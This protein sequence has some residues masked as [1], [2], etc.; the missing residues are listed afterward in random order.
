MV[1]TKEQIHK[2]DARLLSTVGCMLGD[3]TTYALEGSIFSA[4]TSIQWL[5]DEMEFFADASK[6]ERLIDEK[7]YDSENIVEIKRK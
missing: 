3:K 4:G 2:S 1:N 6:S 5:R 7:L